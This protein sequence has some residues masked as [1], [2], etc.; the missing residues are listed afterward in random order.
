MKKNNFFISTAIP[1]VNA[2]PHVGFAFEFVMTDAV[3]RYKRLLGKD[4]FFI[5]GTDDN[6]LK[7]VQAAEAQNEEVSVYINKSAEKFEILAKDLNA[8]ID[9]FIR[10]S[11]DDDHKRGAQKLWKLCEKDL[12]KKSY[13]GLYCTGCEEFKTEKD[14][15]NGECPEHPGKKLENINEENYF[16]KLSNYA[17]ELLK[18]IES[19]ELQIIPESR[20]NETISFIKGGLE[21]FSA[22]RSNERAKNW[23]VSVPGDD[24]QKMYVWFD[25]L[26]NYINGI[27]F[28]DETEQF[29]KFWNYGE[30]VHVIGKGINRFHTIYWPAMLLSAGVALPKKVVIHGYIT[31][32]A[33]KMSKSLGNVINPSELIE[34]YK[35]HAGDLAGDAFRFYI[36][37]HIN[38]FE[39]SPMTKEL[40]AEAYN[41]GLANGLG[42][43]LSRVLTMAENYGVEGVDAKEGIEEIK[44]LENYEISKFTDNLWVRLAILDKYIQE[45]EP[46]KKFKVDPDGA[47]KDVKYLLN[48]I[49][50][51]VPEL[52]III[53]DTA[54]KI[55]ELLKAGKKPTEPL[56]K[57]I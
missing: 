39:D 5:S 12:Y 16:F 36:L 54:E 11:V 17:D 50:N 31:A 49:A 26:S 22:S 46:F 8:S 10:T 55:K 52:S 32:G 42:N 21:D 34:E 13:S 35:V 47:K 14:L 30:T 56:F 18:K 28:A 53:P 48:E 57:R 33:Q 23:G 37:R 9:R 25:A 19:N 41:A 3:A 2:D 6:A 20:R 43:L 40:F 24:T 44:D 38:T 4:V 1:Y 15:V 29:K 7:N 27:G 45:N 51:L